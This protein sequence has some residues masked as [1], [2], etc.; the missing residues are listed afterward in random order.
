M[1]GALT[2]TDAKATTSLALVRLCRGGGGF[3][4]GYSCPGVQRPQTQ[5]ELGNC[6]IAPSLAGPGLRLLVSCPR[7]RG[8]MTLAPGR[9]WPLISTVSLQGLDLPRD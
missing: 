4:A 2:P 8:S 6:L 5:R 1:E 7:D 3:P 9:G